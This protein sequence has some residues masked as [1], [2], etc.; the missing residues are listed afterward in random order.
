MVIF[1]FIGKTFFV[2][3]NNLMTILKKHHCQYCQYETY[4]STNLKQHMLTHTGERP[5]AC[6]L[7]SYRCN[8]KA[9]L[10]RHLKLKHHRSDGI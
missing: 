9:N 4:Y 2:H 10:R 1:D 8:V 3:E 7:C 5:F 6:S